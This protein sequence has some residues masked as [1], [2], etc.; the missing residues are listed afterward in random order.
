MDFTKDCGA[1]QFTE[2][3][4]W[5]DRMFLWVINGEIQ[6]NCRTKVEVGGHD[7]RE[8]ASPPPQSPPFHGPTD[9]K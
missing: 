4:V 6:I 1:A 7:G 5:P 3:S 2:L 9:L 8:N